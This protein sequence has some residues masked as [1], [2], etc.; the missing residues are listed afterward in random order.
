M[1]IPFFNLKRQYG[2]LQAELEQAVLA[3]MRACTFIDGD[4]VKALE[5]ELAAYLKVK[6]AITCGNGTDALKIALKALG[7]HAGDEV[8]TTPYTFFAS[9]E[10]IAAVGGV[11]VFVDI[12]PV[13]LN[14]DPARLE[15][16]ITTR[17]RGIMPVHIFGVP[18]D[19]ASINTIARQYN[20]FVLEDACQAI[21]ADVCGKKAG[22]L[23]DAG[24]F[25]FYPTKNLAAFGD[26]GMICTDRDDIATVCRALKAHGSGRNGA[27]AARL[28]GHTTDGEELNALGLGDGLYD[29]CKYYNYL[30]GD[31]SRL[32]S[33][34]AAVLRVKLRHLEKLTQ[35]R[36][37][38]A[39]R[40][41]QA[42]AD[43][44]L[45]LPPLHLPDTSQCWHQYCVLAPDKDALTADLNAAG[46]GTGAFYPVPL[47]LQ[48]A[49]QYLGYRKD[50]LPV[51]EAACAR[52]VCLPVFPELEPEEQDEIVSIIR[53]HYGLA[54]LTA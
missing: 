28:L 9:A 44:P 52:S 48:K 43:T 24:C 14:L 7:V 5:T 13:T 32:D 8:I 38:I 37:A 1:K 23:G 2:L 30:I 31:N 42:L 12:D 16:A 45:C 26:G 41:T 18:A 36:G 17:T 20:L 6:H 21:G 19:M 25:S 15:A 29:P 27:H 33:I 50:D 3:S 35:K 54:D 53:R 22:T 34:Q 47:H 51:A 49:F 39:A 46:I 10:A 11:P 4:D 40:Y